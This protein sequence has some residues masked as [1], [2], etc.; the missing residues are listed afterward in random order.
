[1]FLNVAREKFQELFSFQFW[2]IL[3]RILQNNNRIIHVKG[4]F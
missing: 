3:I 1:M 2:F 4:G